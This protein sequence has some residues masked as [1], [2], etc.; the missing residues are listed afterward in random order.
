MSVKMFD[1]MQLAPWLAE[2][3]DQGKHRQIGPGQGTASSGYDPMKKLVQSELFD[4]LI[5]KPNL[6]KIKDSARVD[7]FDVDRNPLRLVS[8]EKLLLKGMAPLGGHFDAE[9]PRGIRGAKV[10]HNSLSWATSRSARLDQS[11]IPMVVAIF[12]DIDLA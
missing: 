10:G 6:T 1:N 5:G 11:P 12:M 3:G 2:P 7:G 8:P 9:V 4:Q